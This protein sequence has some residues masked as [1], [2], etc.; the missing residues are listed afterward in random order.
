[1]LNA[2]GIWMTRGKVEMK[3]RNFSWEHNKAGKVSFKFGE[4]AIRLGVL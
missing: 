3:F 4:G 1:M 2:A